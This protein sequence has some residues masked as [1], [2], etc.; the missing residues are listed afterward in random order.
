MIKRALTKF[1]IVA[2]ILAATPARHQ[3]PQP[4]THIAL[5]GVNYTG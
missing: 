4:S 3:D 1:A 5:I 2:A